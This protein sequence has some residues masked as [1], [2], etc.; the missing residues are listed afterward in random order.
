MAIKKKL[1]KN[2]LRS[3]LPA[4]LSKYGEWFFSDDKD[5]LYVELK[6]MRAVL[7]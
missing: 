2:E 7:Y 1:S 6:D 4:K 5:Q 3:L